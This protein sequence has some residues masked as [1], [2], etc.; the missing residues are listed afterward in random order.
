MV[1]DQEEIEQASTSVAQSF[2]NVDAL[3]PTT[4]GIPAEVSYGL[5]LCNRWLMVFTG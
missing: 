2:V 4:N 5:H 1:T 3:L